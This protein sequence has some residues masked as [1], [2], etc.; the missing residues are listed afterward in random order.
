[1]AMSCF[2]AFGV[3][4][5]GDGTDLNVRVNGKLTEFPDAKPYIDSSNRTMIPVRFVAEN[6]GAEV[7]WIGATNTASIMKDSI[8]VEITIGDQTLRVTDH[9]ETRTVTMDTAAV[10]K[11]NRTYVPIRFVAEALCAYVDYSSTYHTVGIYSAVLTAEQISMLTALPYTQPKETLGYEE[12]K[13]RYDADTLTFLYGTDREAFQSY[14]NAR[15]HLYHMTFESNVDE[16]YA[17]VVRQAADAVDYDSENLTVR[18]L[19]DTSCI[20]QSDSMDRLT[21]AVRGIVVVQLNV[22]PLELTGSE[23]AMLCALGFKKLDVGTMYIPVD[24]HMNVGTGR[25]SSLHT[26]APAGD[27]Y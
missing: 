3:S 22:S 21:C 27:Q 7:T 12:A 4:D 14:A 6:L 5:A 23:T 24:I 20:Y 9:G 17:G 16:Y 2:S 10:L 25:T 11:E 1:M 15:E 8:L 26:V 18:F 13:E 19:A